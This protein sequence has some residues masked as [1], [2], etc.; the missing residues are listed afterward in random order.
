VA[1]LPIG[2]DDEGLVLLILK[3]IVVY[4]RHSSVLVQR[5]CLTASI[6]Y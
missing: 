6:L 3:L 1:G 5:I 2:L 4:G